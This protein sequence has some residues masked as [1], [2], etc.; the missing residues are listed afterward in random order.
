MPIFTTYCNLHRL[1]D[2]AEN[3]LM[4]VLGE[5]NLQSKI[6]LYMQEKNGSLP[7]IEMEFKAK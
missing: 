7:T 3:Y 2:I 6:C 1:H 4:G 5:A